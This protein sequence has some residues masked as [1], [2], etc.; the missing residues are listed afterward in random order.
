MD[1]IEI[2]ILISINLA[3]KQEHLS[4]SYV[5]QFT[6]VKAPFETS[7]SRIK[8]AAS[9]CLSW[10]S[11]TP[12]LLSL[13]LQK[14]HGC[15]QSSPRPHFSPEKIL[16]LIKKSQVWTLKLMT[17]RLEFLCLT[18]HHSTASTTPNSSNCFLFKMHQSQRNHMKNLKSEYLTTIS[19]SKVGGSL[20]QT[21]S[22]WKNIISEIFP[23]ELLPGVGQFFQSDCSNV[24]LC[25][26]RIPQPSP[27]QQH[28][29][30]APALFLSN[31][32]T[33]W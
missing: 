21:S 27:A 19:R 29:L 30:I 15:F 31:Y 10:W 11:Q 3:R 7:C 28:Y 6:C 18:L 2:L 16:R 24:D 9:A 4:F 32:F 13:S 5:A 23:G 22:T 26:L 12:P 14:Q 8:A 20:L 1:H 17:S 25:K 33:S